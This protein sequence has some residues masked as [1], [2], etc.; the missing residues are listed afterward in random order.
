MRP[1]VCSALVRPAAPL[2]DPSSE[3]ML[4][5]AVDDDVLSRA[6]MQHFPGCYIHETLGAGGV[7]ACFA[8]VLVDNT[9]VAVKVT[10][11]GYKTA[12][13][14]IEAFAE[15]RNAAH[16]LPDTRAEGMLSR[17]DSVPPQLVL[18]PRHNACPLPF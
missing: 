7:S 1:Y 18:V 3:G 11:K 14:N 5:D 17:A 10:R 12:G 9:E 2:S 4:T 13:T 8:A 16:C 6:I 15:V